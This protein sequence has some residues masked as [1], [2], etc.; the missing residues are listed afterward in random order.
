M[1]K[2]KDRRFLDLDDVLDALGISENKFS[3]LVD[4][5]QLLQPIEWG[6][7]V[8]RWSQED[9]A[10]MEFLLKNLHRLRK[11]DAKEQDRLAKK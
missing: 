4:A 3:E 11:S 8:L 9:L 1:A 6:P 10:V 5:G 7:K 2:Q